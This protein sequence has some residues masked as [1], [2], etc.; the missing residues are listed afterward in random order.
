[1]RQY[2]KK[3]IIKIKKSTDFVLGYI[4]SKILF[5]SPFGEYVI[6]LDNLFFH[7]WHAWN[8]VDNLLVDITILKRGGKDFWVGK[9]IFIFVEPVCNTL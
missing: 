5:G 2:F 7:D 3:K 1:M 8:Y 4:E 9:F 6:E